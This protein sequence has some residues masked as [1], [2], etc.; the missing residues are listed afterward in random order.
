MIR[1]GIP[2]AW[3]TAMERANKAA[4]AMA[5]KVCQKMNIFKS[6]WQERFRSLRTPEE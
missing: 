2:C 5:G 1:D 4:A 3:I 6:Y